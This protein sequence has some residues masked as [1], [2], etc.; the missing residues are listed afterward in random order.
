MKNSPL[1]FLLVALMCAA[2]SHG[3]G[4]PKFSLRRLNG[5]TVNV[6]ESIRKKT[7][8]LNFWASWCSTC[9]EEIPELV[10]LKKAPGAESAVFY[11]INVGESKAQVRHFVEK[12]NN[13]I[14][15]SYEKNV[16]VYFIGIISTC[17]G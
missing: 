14:R 15:G 5:G 6:G 17:N 7:V 12:N 8:V 1:V 16:S 4:V 2:P 13:L 9:E 11:G 3:A 10:A